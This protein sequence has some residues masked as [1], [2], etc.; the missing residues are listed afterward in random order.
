MTEIDEMKI[1][2]KLV[3]H[4]RFMGTCAGGF[5]LIAFEERC[6]FCGA[7]SYE[8]CKRRDAALAQS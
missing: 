1:A 3:E 8:R 2:A 6:R 7:S 5:P 4:E